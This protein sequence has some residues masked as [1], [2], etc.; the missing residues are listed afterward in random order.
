MNTA[1]RGLLNTDPNG[2]MMEIKEVLPT[3]IL[4]FSV[5]VK[6]V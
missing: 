1:S 2:D 5:A 3:H 4:R 6:P